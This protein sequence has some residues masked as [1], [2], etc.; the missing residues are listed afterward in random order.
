MPISAGKITRLRGYHRLVF[1]HRAHVYRLVGSG[2]R[3][4][5]DS[6][7]F[8]DDFEQSFAQRCEINASRY[9]HHLQPDIGVNFLPLNR[10]RQ[11][12]DIAQTSSGAAPNFG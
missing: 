12:A 2:A 5:N 10:L 3:R 8:D 4:E 7:R 1:A 6:A 9:W 11:N